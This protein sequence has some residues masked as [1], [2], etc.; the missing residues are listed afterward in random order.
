MYNKSFEDKLEEQ[1]LQIADVRVREV[2]K[3]IFRELDSRQNNLMTKLRDD[4]GKQISASRV[5]Q[6]TVCTALCR[7]EDADKYFGFSAMADLGT[8]IKCSRLDDEQNIQVIGY[9]FYNGSFSDYKSFCDSERT[10]TGVLGNEK[11]TCTVHSSDRLVKCEEKLDVLSKLYGFKEPM[12]YSPWSRRLVEIRTEIPGSLKPERN[13]VLSILPEN[14]ELSDK[15]LEGYTL[16]WNLS[17]ESNSSNIISELPKRIGDEKIYTYMHEKL[18][19]NTSGDDSLSFLWVEPDALLEYDLRV[20]SVSEAGTVISMIKPA[21]RNRS[22][23]LRV[24][25]VKRINVD[26]SLPDSVIYKLKADGYESFINSVR[27]RALEKHRI[28]SASDMNYAVSCFERPGVNIKV[29][30]YYRDEL[31]SVKML[32]DMLKKSGDRVVGTHNSEELLRRAISGAISERN[33]VQLTVRYPR[34]LEYHRNA[35]VELPGQV[36][37]RLIFQFEEDSFFNTDYINFVL[38]AL[39]NRYPELGWEGVMRVR[40]R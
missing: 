2:L 5:P 3:D 31:G 13:A 27:F 19:E 32:M 23:L 36:R 21:P 30:Q 18:R 15:L 8:E 17:F 4:V 28:L 24:C 9:A 10:Y 1:T 26:P 20:S 22:E 14:S 33:G 25:H 16:L 12:I 38:S 34:R 6:L 11:C 29:D 37:V 40:E 7:N 39:E 35:V